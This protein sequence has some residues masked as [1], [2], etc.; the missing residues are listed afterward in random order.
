MRF[1]GSIEHIHVEDFGEFRD[2][3]T[4]G[5]EVECFGV[6]LAIGAQ[7]NNRDAK[8]RHI[9]PSAAKDSQNV[10]KINRNYP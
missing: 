3:V 7:G 8:Q 10:L 2:I 9:V 1:T 4:D 5:S 6:S